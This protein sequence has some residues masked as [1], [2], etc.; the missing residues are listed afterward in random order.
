VHGSEQEIM[1]KYM[2]VKAIQGTLSKGLLCIIRPTEGMEVLGSEVT[3]RKSSRVLFR[4]IKCV[5]HTSD[6]TS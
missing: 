3:Q 2:S 5:I 1:Q 6:I 4:H